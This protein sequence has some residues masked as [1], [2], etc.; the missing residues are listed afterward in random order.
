MRVRSTF[1][2]RSIAVDFCFRT[3]HDS[4]ATLTPALSHGVPRER[5]KTRKHDARTSDRAGVVVFQDEPAA[6]LLELNR[7]GL[8]ADDDF[9]AEAAEADEGAFLEA[10]A[11]DQTPEVLFH[12]KHRVGEH[13]AVGDEL[14]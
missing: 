14:T 6:R 10:A 8:L 1:A 2:R 5:G 7:P 12:A 13:V 11:D 9:C 4:T 3:P